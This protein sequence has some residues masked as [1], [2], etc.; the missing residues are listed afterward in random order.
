MVNRVPVP[1]TAVPVRAI[2]PV[3]A[4]VVAPEKVTVALF[5]TLNEPIVTLFGMFVTFAVTLNITL[6]PAT[7]VPFGVQ[8]VAVLQSPEA[9]FHV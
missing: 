4:D 6:S 2:V 3:Y 7:G 1:V 9:A 5:V 8:F